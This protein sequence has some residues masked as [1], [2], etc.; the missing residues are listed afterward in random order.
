MAESTT[1]TCLQCGKEIKDPGSFCPHCGAELPK[2]LSE[3][4]S[5]AGYWNFYGVF[6]DDEEIDEPKGLGARGTLRFLALACVAAAVIIG[7]ALTSWKWGFS[8]RKAW[9]VWAVGG[10]AAVILVIISF[11]TKKRE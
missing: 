11:F 10:G 8:W 9:P 6:S 4:N 2:P 5:G 3:Q 7:F 1:I